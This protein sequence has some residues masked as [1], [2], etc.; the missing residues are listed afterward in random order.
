MR[1]LFMGTPDFSVP[2]LDAL[3]QANHEIVCVVAQPDKP[4]GRGKKLVS[5]PTIM[6]ARELG[7]PTKQ[8]RAVRRGPFVDWVSQTSF[9]VAV[10][11]AYGRILI[12]KILSYVLT[13]TQIPF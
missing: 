13:T 8:P 6:R 7:I 3:M 1:V 4:K 11:I 12:P 9:D 2:T 10:V 5:P